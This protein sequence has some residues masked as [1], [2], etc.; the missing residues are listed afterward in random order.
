MNFLL[1]YYDYYESKEVYRTLLR[2]FENFDTILKIFSFIFLTE[3]LILLLI[4]VGSLSPMVT[5]S[6]GITTQKMKFSIKDFFSKG[7][8]SSKTDLGQ[9]QRPRWSTLL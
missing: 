9:L 3:N 1:Y 5:F 2:K 8:R 4:Q 7:D 6:F